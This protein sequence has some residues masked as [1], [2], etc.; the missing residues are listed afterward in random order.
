MGIL[1]VPGLTLIVDDD[2]EVDV[3]DD[4]HAS[5]PLAHIANGLYNPH[6]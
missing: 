5:T 1:Y 4:L 3:V 6:I 2:V